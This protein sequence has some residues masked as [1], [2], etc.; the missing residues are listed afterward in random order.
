MTKFYIDESIQDG[1]IET[2]LRFL[3]DKTLLTLRK[4]KSYL[5]MNEERQALID[6]VRNIALVLIPLAYQYAEIRNFIEIFNT[7]FI[8][9][10]KWLESYSDLIPKVDPNPS[11]LE[12][13]N[14]YKELNYNSPEFFNDY[15]QIPKDDL[16]IF[17]SVLN[18]IHKVIDGLIPFY[19]AFPHAS[20]RVSNFIS[21]LPQ[22]YFNML[23][24][25][26]ENFESGRYKII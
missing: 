15:F 25:I 5:L 17:I 14:N 20:S 9:I 3:N 2:Y 10:M 22:E 18:D 1:W 6:P 26:N 4:N 24:R 21:E 7:R 19:K 8:D 23:N 16:E 12:A 13:L 11:D